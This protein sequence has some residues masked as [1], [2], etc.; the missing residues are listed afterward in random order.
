MKAGVAALQE[1]LGY[2]FK[3]AG[4]LQAALTHPSHEKSNKKI[5]SYER[6]EFLGDRVLSL[7]VAEWLFELYANE[8][9]G[10]L[11]KRHAA[12]VNRD[13]LADIAERVNLPESLQLL[14]AQDL[15]RGRV[16]ILSDALEALLGA[17]YLDA[18]D[19]ALELMRPIIRDLWQQDVHNIAVPQDPKS[20]LQEWAQGR[21]LPLPDYQ[22]VSQTGPA[23]A[24]HYVMR[25]TVQGQ[26][27]AEAEGA[28]KRE[29]EKKA[30]AELWNKVRSFEGA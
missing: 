10:G 2:V 4:L 25:V 13:I 5:S 27:P 9:E 23:H 30:A 20:A 16:N 14:H 15:V 21:G 29:A 1:K 11:A 24:P 17:I 3:D 12:L 6:L 28:S 8:S 26:T 19:K 22:V 18:G 7:L